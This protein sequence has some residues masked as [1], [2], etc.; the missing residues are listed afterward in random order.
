[1]LWH[2]P[3]AATPEWLAQAKPFGWIGVDLFFVLSGYLIGTELLTSPGRGRRLD[4]PAFYL[5]R[6][7]RIL[8]HLLFKSL[9]DFQRIH[10]VAAA[11]RPHR[12]SEILS[13]PR[14]RRG[15]PV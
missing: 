7:F 6:S 2:L 14:L 1:M 13:T 11:L 8:Q 9:V 15:Y 4:L 12:Q 3:K 10:P 5:R